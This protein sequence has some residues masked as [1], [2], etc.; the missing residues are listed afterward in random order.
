MTGAF[1]LS[2]TGTVQLTALICFLK[3]IGCSVLDFGMMMDYKAALGATNISRQEWI[4]LVKLGRN[5][6]MLEFET[7]KM[8][9]LAEEKKDANAIHVGDEGGT[10]MNAKSVIQSFQRRNNVATK[11][12][13][14]AKLTDELGRSQ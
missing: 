7:R 3:C 4:E 2:G 8:I 14:K 9:S 12:K 1:T 13:Q 6:S 5:D 11:T 10:L